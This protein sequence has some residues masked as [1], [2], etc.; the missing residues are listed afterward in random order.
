MTTIIKLLVAALFLNAVAQAGLAAYKYYNFEDAVHEALVFAPSAAD[1]DIVERIGG[2]ADEQDV[3]LASANI[4]ITRTQN[5]VKV[6][7]SYVEDIT[8]VP[9]IYTKAW[10]FSPSS[11]ARV[12]AGISLPQKQPRRK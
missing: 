2:L 7:M 6:Q 10:T 8:L 1:T 11:S 3:P 5:E 9:G 12:I 4:Q